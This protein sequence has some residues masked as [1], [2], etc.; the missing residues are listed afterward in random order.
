M[1]DAELATYVDA[2][3][4]LLAAIARVAGG[5]VVID[6]SRLPTHTLLLVRNP[7]LDVR[8]GHLVRDS[9]GVAFSN[10]K[11]LTS[12]EPTLLPQHGAMGSAL[13]YDLNHTLNGLLDG[14]PDLARMRLRYEDLVAYPEARLRE[15][16]A[17]AQL[18]VQHALPFLHDRQ[19][20]LGSNH[21][22][23]GNP[24]RFIRDALTLSLYDEWRRRLSA[25]DRR[26]RTLL[27][28]PLMHH[29]AYPRR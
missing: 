15:V 12:G 28:W 11:T 5:S 25:R 8:M 3:G 13:R 1:R 18:G 10:Q 22:V 26:T 7:E 6:S 20:S 19:V 29:Y 14:R 21:L 2:L 23:D 17:H 4:R 16:A 27:T 24:V 9:R